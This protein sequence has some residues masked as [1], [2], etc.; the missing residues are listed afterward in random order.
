[1]VNEPNLP[2][3]PV[4]PNR[5]KLMGFAL[6]LAL[7]AGLGAIALVEARRI[8]T[9][10][11]E[12]DVSYFLGVPTVAIIPRTFTVA[13]RGRAR[14]LAFKRRAIFLVIGAAAIPALALLLNTLEIFQILGRK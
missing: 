2:Q 10:Q 9:I 14:Q 5:A 8:A 6:A 12:R 7:V 1:M 13:E 3:S 11:D 4:A